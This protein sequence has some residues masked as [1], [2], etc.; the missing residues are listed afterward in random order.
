MNVTI[1]TNVGH[2][3]A[4]GW[5]NGLQATLLFLIGVACAV[6]LILL[7]HNWYPV[8]FP[9]KGLPATS[10]ATPPG[11]NSSHIKGKPMERVAINFTDNV[12]F[13]VKTSSRNYRKRLSILMLT[14]FQTVSKHKVSRDSQL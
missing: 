7:V 6:F 2:R 5:K 4:A 3:P 11:M 8:L 1:T 14:W 9:V 13:T 12:Y 10:R